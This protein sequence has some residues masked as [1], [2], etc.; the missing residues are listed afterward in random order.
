MEAAKLARDEKD[1]L[2]ALLKELRGAGRKQ[3]TV[4]L[5]GKSSVGK[6]SLV[7]S[8]LGEAV[9]RVQAF[10]LQA[11][12]EITKTVVRQVA[13]GDPEVDGLRL[14]LIDTCGLEDPE[15]GDTVNFGLHA[16]QLGGQLGVAEEQGGVV[17]FGGRMRRRGP[18]LLLVLRELLELLVLL[19]LLGAAAAGMAL[20]GSQSGVTRSVRAGQAS[21]DGSVS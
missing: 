4:L 1:V 14:K 20:R 13:V 17:A 18:L 2:I 16:L 7:N 10:K 3:L 19:K 5:L 21:H 11:D 6:S 8:L 15:A 9:V 12:T